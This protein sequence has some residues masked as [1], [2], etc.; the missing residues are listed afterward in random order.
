MDPN[1]EKW[2]I[3]L[4]A[5]AKVRLQFG[6]KKEAKAQA[7]AAVFA[8]VD[9]I[10]GD[11][12]VG[13]SF[14]V[15]QGGETVHSMT[16]DSEQIDEIESEEASETSGLSAQELK[17]AG[18]A[19]RKLVAMEKK[20]EE[21]LRAAGYDDKEIQETIT[22]E[23]YFP[24]VREKLMPE[25]L[26]PNKYSSTKQML[27]ATNKLYEEA[28]KD[29][30]PKEE[31]ADSF[32][33]AKKGLGFAAE[34]GKGITDI[35]ATQSGLANH[36]KLAGDIINLT[37]VVLNTGLTAVEAISKDQLRGS[38]DD[39]VGNVGT[40]LSQSIGFFD[41]AHGTNLA[42]AVG[43][44]YTAATKT[45]M[46]VKYLSD[47]PP[48]IEAALDSFANGFVEAFNAGAGKAK[49][50]QQGDVLKAAG[51]AVAGA[52]KAAKNL[53]TLKEAV[54]NRDFAGLVQGMTDMAKDSI[55]VGFTAKSAL[56]GAGKSDEEKK[57]LDDERDALLAKIN[58]ALEAGG[59]VLATGAAV[60]SAAMQGEISGAAEAVVANI[61]KSLH[62]M[63]AAFAPKDVAATVEKA[64][65][66]S[67]SAG[68]VANF[69]IK[70]DPAKA[71]TALGNGFAA[72]LDLCNPDPDSKVFAT[73]GKTMA[74]VFSGAVK[75]K[76]IKDALDAG[77]TATVIEL[78]ATAGKDAAGSV[79]DVKGV[80]D[81]A[82]KSDDQKTAQ[83]QKRQDIADLTGAGVDTVKDIG[84]AAAAIKDLLADPKVQAKIAD[85]VAEKQKEDAKAEI[86]REQKEFDRMLSQVDEGGAGAD[87]LDR[88][89][90]P[91][92]A[93][94]QAHHGS[95][96]EDR[97]RR[98]G[99]GGQVR[100]RPGGGRRRG[101][102]C[103]QPDGGGQPG[104]GPQQVAQQPEGR[105]GGRQRL[106][107]VH[108]QLR[109]QST[110]AVLL[111]RH[112]VGPA[113]GA[114]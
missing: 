46:V 38:L 98:P 11:I 61:G 91:A 72:T 45:A 53:K 70:G 114:S 7:L 64:Y 41:S 99:H 39:I 84:K 75:A 55:A 102:A 22:E 20:L 111:L 32:A 92:D 105:Q 82:G 65:A 104:H 34:M 112:Q 18:E 52:I 83:A 78:L 43:S 107:V 56:A 68:L 57:K 108:Q 31:E 42:S 79:L 33:K 27:D 66:A 23:L 103:R 101:Q 14:S 25:N 88:D 1:Q 93:E 2:L 12:K 54:E 77:D 6:P 28:I 62:S 3:K 80:F 90:D 69:L 24:L 59:M 40:I 8:E 44:V 73:V 63:L 100:A 113:T 26:V 87:A 106:F 21:K 51:E 89:P 9:T 5:A 4:A 50:Q 74:A 110:G 49:D 47:S 96:D 58:A 109:D 94:R 17:R 35:L 36:A 15:T 85:K 16:E 10:K 48:Q 67:T 76:E 29:L 71:I 30:D 60:Y 19:Q 37:D 86:E 97:R 13:M 95:G 81:D